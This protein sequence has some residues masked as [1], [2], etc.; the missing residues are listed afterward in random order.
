MQG[1]ELLELEK[2]TLNEIKEK[3]GLWDGIINANFNR[4]L[5]LAIAGKPTE[6]TEMQIEYHLGKMRREKLPPYVINWYEKLYQEFLRY[7][8]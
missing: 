7:N 4:Y 3:A 5:R 2:I 8:L 6:Q 1:A